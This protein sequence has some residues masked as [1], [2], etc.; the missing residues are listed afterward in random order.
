MVNNKDYKYDNKAMIKFLVRFFYE[1]RK[2]GIEI[3]DK[4][5]F[6]SYLYAI[7][8]DVRNKVLHNNFSNEDY[9]T[10]KMALEQLEY[11]LCF[12]TYLAT[13]ENS[14]IIPESKDLE[15]FIKT[16]PHLEEYAIKRF[17]LIVHEW[18]VLT[19][20]DKKITD[21][22]ITVLSKVP[23]REYSICSSDP[24]MPFHYFGDLIFGSKEKVSWDLVTNNIPAYTNRMSDF[25]SNSHDFSFI[26]PEEQKSFYARTSRHVNV[27][28][29]DFVIVQ[30]YVYDELKSAYVFTL[31]DG[32]DYDKIINIA[33]T[34]NPGINLTNEKP[35]VRVLTIY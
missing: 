29:S 5:V 9:I 3:I 4:P 15:E 32:A 25:G 12:K 11:H 35:H 30:G 10:I 18:H 24:I 27:N 2:Q 26:H 8:K 14:L 7:S 17:E 34:T 28:N 33:M 20:R 31:K 19:T 23:N 22:N 21:S 13:N 6:V 16:W 1:A